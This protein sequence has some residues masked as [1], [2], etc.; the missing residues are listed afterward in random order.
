MREDPRVATAAVLPVKRFERAKERLHP[1]LD[2]ASRRRLAFAMVSDVVDALQR[3]RLLEVILLVSAEAALEPLVAGRV[4]RLQD[5][6]ERGQSAAALIGMARCRELGLDRA[7]LVPGDCP[8][9]D[10]H[11]I[12]LLVERAAPFD[13]VIVPDRHGSGTNAVALRCEAA[14]QPRFGPGSLALH[15]EEAGKRDLRY[16]V[17][18][19][20]SLA[21]DVDTADDLAQLRLALERSHERAP[22]TRAALSEIQR[23]SPLPSPA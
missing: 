8:L 22:A 3:V 13:L 4:E 5:P 14:F 15:V 18:R 21:L 17:E 23:A 2:P 7:I 10:P 12:E 11:E 16:L 20:R 6:E 1:H 19:V 9:V